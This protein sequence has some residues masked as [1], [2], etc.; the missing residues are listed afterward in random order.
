MWA[1][2]VLNLLSN[3]LKF[4]FEGGVAVAPRARPAARR[5]ASCRHRHRHRAGRAGAALRALPPR[6]TAPRSRSHEGTGIGLA[7]VAELVGAARRRGRRRERAGRGQHVHGDGAVR[8][9]APARRPASCRRA[10]RRRPPRAPSGFLAEAMRWLRPDAGR[11]PVRTGP[12]ARR[13]PGRGSSSSTTTPT[14]ATTWRRCCADD[15]RVATA[16]DGAAALAL[17]RAEPPD[18]VLTDVM[19]PELDGFGLL[20]AL[21]A[22]RRHEP[23]PGRHA[24]GARGRGGARSRASTRA[25]TTTSSSR[26]P[27]ASCW[28]ASTPTSS[29]TGR[30]GRATRSSAAGRSSTRRERLAGVGSWEI[31]LA[32]SGVRGSVQ[33]LRLLAIDEDELQAA[34]L[35][36][37]LTY[38]HDADR[39]ASRR[40]RGRGRS[41]A[42]RST[43]SAA[44]SRATARGAHVPRPRRPAAGR[45]RRADRAARQQPGRHRA[46]R[47]GGGAPH[48]RRDRGGGRARAP[49][50]RRAAAQPAAGR[51]SSSPSTSSS[52]PTTAPA[53]RAPR[54]AATGTTSSS[55]AP[56]GPRSSS[57]TSWAAACGPRPSWG[58][59]GPRS[60]RTP[61]STSARP[62]CSSS[63]TASSATLGDGPDR[64]LRVRRLRPDDRTLVY[65]NAGHLP[66]LLSVADAPPHRL[67]G[68][69]PPLGSGP[70]DVAEHQVRVPDGDLLALYTDGLVER[71]PGAIDAGIDALAEALGR[72][73]APIESL[74]GALVDAAAA[75]RPGRRRRR[76][77]R[78]RPAGR[79]GRVV[80]DARDRAEARSIGEA[81]DFVAAALRRRE[82]R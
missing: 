53:S 14:C 51:R 72:R 21:R 11:R 64:H 37:A 4:T 60:A 19:M 48:R 1:K 17:A 36:G 22:D 20:A 73:A 5:A 31:D 67:D 80:G 2:I 30:G 69:A 8:Q 24:L 70:V 16:R 54:S 71:R 57:A 45:G 6:R 29:S 63:S 47:G 40:D 7:L 41:A 3:A 79:G 62:T 23:R 82:R 49:H 42:C 34:G 44:S 43:S 38:V 35:E 9:R 50:R 59:S 56:G 66:P 65:A 78:A 76:A 46:A 75:G 28:R 10:R 74:P 18:L 32:T 13:A 55:S 26:S 68:H 81:R 58:S 61:G 12:A 39:S 52:P 15:Y 25:P 77:R 33:F 27:R